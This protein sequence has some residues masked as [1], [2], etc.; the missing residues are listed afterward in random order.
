M[1]RASVP[2]GLARVMRPWLK[3]VLRFKPAD[4]VRFSRDYFTSLCNREEQEFLANYA[5]D[6]EQDLLQQQPPKDEPEAKMAPPALGSPTNAPSDSDIS[7]SSLSVPPRREDARYMTQ[8]FAHDGVLSLPKDPEQKRLSRGDLNLAA[9]QGLASDGASDDGATKDPAAAFFVIAIAADAIRKA[10]GT[11]LGQNLKA[12]QRNKG[13]RDASWEIQF[14]FRSSPVSL[15]FPDDFP[16]T[17]A[18][19]RLKGSVGTGDK[20]RVVEKKIRVEATA[21]ST[22]DCGPFVKEVLGHLNEESTQ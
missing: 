10:L 3:E 13:N 9:T 15:T 21:S 8:D 7:A 19:L 22:A 20:R 5:R 14:E 11:Q 6:R 4:I 16:R 2:D 17:R 1:Q 12:P 18:A